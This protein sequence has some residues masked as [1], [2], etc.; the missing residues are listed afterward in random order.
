MIAKMLG[1]DVNLAKVSEVSLYAVQ[2]PCSTPTDTGKALSS[3]SSKK[4]RK[5]MNTG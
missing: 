1:A 3:C 4:A 2:S 5:K